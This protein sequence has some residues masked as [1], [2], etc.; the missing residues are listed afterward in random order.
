MP[1]RLELE[2]FVVGGDGMPG[3]DAKGNRLGWDEASA[4]HP[5]TAGTHG[6]VLRMAIFHRKSSDEASR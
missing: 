2:H 4:G 5:R 1:E 3:A 6:K